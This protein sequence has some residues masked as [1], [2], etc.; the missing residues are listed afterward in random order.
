MTSVFVL[1]QPQQGY[2][3][4][5]D[6]TA[7]LADKFILASHEKLLPEISFGTRGELR[8]Y[9]QTDGRLFCLGFAV[10]LTHE[11]EY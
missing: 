7:Q 8:T 10:H 4:F 9:K 3:S 6:A 5:S 2:L 11:S 1:S